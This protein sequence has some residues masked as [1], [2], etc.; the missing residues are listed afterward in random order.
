MIEKKERHQAECF[1]QFKECPLNKTEF[2]NWK[3]NSDKWSS[4][5][6]DDVIAYANEHHFENLI[7]I[8]NTISATFVENYILPKV[9]LI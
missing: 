6:I 8:D 1:A 3:R 5:T 9:V 7:A 2:R 4:Y